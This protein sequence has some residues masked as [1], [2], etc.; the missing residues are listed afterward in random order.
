[1][2]RDPHPFPTRRSSDLGI[3]QLA[4]PRI[5]NHLKI[6]R[7]ENLIVER[8]SGSWRYYRV[9]PDHLEAQAR[10]LWPALETAWQNDPHLLADDK[11]DRKSTRLN[12]SHVKIS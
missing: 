11:R 9:D 8:R 7:E 5:S 10:P 6:L 1:P 3:T 4:Q 12:S 2:P